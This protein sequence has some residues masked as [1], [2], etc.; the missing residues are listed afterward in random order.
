MSQRGITRCRVG[1]TS[2]TESKGDLAHASSAT[3]REA[4]S[5]PHAPDADAAHVDKYHGADEHAFAVELYSAAHHNPA[6]AAVAHS[7]V[8]HAAAG[9]GKSGYAAPPVGVNGL[10]CLSG[11]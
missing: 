6:V 7:T 11:S 9:A 8:A 3:V 5:G 4:A 10:H 1:Q 2:H